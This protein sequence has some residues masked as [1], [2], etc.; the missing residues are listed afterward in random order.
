MLKRFFNNFRL[1]RKI[2]RLECQMKKVYSD[3][4]HA[5]SLAARLAE[6][7]GYKVYVGIDPAEPD[8]PVFYIELPTGQLSWH[9]S[10]GYFEKLSR[11]F[12][13]AKPNH[14]DGHSTKTK[15]HRIRQ[16]LRKKK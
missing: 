14:W 3:R 1:R 15:H 9:V 2:W 6:D 13:R 4:N 5:V 7:Q 11:L 10:P 8:W 16:F 12:K